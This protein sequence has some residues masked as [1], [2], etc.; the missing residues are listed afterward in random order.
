MKICVSSGIIT[1]NLSHCK[2]VPWTTRSLWSCWLII[3]CVL[4]L[5]YPVIRI[6][7]TQ[8]ES[9][10]HLSSMFSIDC[11]ILP[12]DTSRKDV[13]VKDKCPC[14][15][16]SLKWLILVIWSQ[17][18]SLTLLSFGRVSLVEY[19][20]EIWKPYLQWFKNIAKVKVFR[21]VG[22]RPWSRTLGQ[23]FGMNKNASSQEMHMWNM[24]AKPSNGSI[25]IGKVNVFRI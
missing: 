5:H 15:Q 3:R 4:V 18:R 13:F 20:C 17:T 16:Q 23:K 11:Q 21:K 22:Q 19:A 1:S 9:L 8:E 14:W 10:L 12:P 25:V 2:L 7:P 24:E 6:I